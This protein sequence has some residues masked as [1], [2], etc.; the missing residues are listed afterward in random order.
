MLLL[1]GATAPAVTCLVLGVVLLLG[2]F[3]GKRSR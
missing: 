1:A 2:G 3:L